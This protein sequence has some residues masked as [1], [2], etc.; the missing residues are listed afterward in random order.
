MGFLRVVPSAFLGGDLLESPV[1]KS[2]KKHLVAAAATSSSIG[3]DE[4][5][6]PLWSFILL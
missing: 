2:Q 4:N 6:D 1:E 5:S 3:L